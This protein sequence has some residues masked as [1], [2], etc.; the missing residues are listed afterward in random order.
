MKP[1]LWIAIIL[2]LSSCSSPN[3]KDQE[4]N[5]IDPI[6][7]EKMA[8]PKLQYKDELFEMSLNMNKTV[9]AKNEPIDYSVSLTYIGEEESITI[10]GGRTYIGFYLTDG[11]KFEMEG[12]NT[13][14]LVATTLK[15][16]ET[17]QF[18]FY[19]S[20]G[21]SNDD[22]DA[23]FWKQFYEEKDLL[24][25]SGTYFISANCLFSLGE[26]V[27][28]SHYDGSVYTTITVE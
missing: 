16:G 10:W 22:P 19:K 25:P 11:K 5:S 27:V 14:E 20:G 6:L 7:M 15:K 12:A 3:N 26:E 21:Y 28:N 17:Q 2:I 8:E 1:L 4:Q 18:P 13:T 23:S 24:L 9:F